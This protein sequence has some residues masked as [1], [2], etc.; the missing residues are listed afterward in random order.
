MKPQELAR[1][2]VETYV[3]THKTPEITDV[4]DGIEV[5]KAGAF[6][7]IKTKEGDLRGCIGTIKATTESITEEII[8]NAVSAAFNDPRFSPVEEHE[9]KNLRYSVDVLHEAE[10]VAS[11]SQ[12]DPKVFGIIVISAS[13]RQALLLPDLEGLDTIEKQVSA[14][15][16]KAVIPVNEKVSI[17]RFK[18]DRYSE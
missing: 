13:G 12:L 16:R 3:R 6:V 11:F 14:C 17:F 4:L 10:P 15:M 8:N 5:Q 7:S 18:V 1:Q 9:L 2:T